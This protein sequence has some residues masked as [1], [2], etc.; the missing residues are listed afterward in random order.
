MAEN[1]FKKHQLSN[2]NDFKAEWAS[3]L[4]GQHEAGEE[5]IIDPDSE[6]YLSGFVFRGMGCSNHN[7]IS[8]FDRLIQSFLQPPE[9]IKSLYIDAIANYIKAGR[10]IRAFGDRDNEFLFS[11]DDPM[12]TSKETFVKAEAFAQHHGFPTRLLDWSSSPYIAAFFA[13]SNYSVCESDY[14]SIWCLDTKGAA[15]ILEKDIQIV[16]E[17]YYE[18]TRLISQKGCFTRNDSNL[19]NMNELF[20]KPDRFFSNPTR[21]VLH[22]L[23]IPVSEGDAILKDLN[24]MGIDFLRVYPDLE[25]MKEIAKYKLVEEAA[26]PSR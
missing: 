19:P 10:E 15:K 7:L 3:Y 8:S 21:P 16:D 6:D 18:N 1:A 13:A 4:Q 5:G 25:G 17:D 11:P 2:W 23:D 14:I 22:R 12:I 9:D 20:Q 24:Y 26:K